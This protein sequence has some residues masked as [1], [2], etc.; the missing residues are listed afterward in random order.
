ML[1]TAEGKDDGYHVH[2]NHVMYK[3]VEIEYLGIP[4]SDFR[5]FNLSKYFQKC[6]DYIDSALADGG[7]NRLYF[8]FKSHFFDIIFVFL[9]YR[10]T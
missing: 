10:C 5:T 2:T 7:N 9:E 8:L 1:N 6:A 4:A 3:K